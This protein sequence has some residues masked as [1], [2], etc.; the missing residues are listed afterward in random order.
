MLAELNSKA[1]VQVH[2]LHMEW[3]GSKD[4][5][6][7]LVEV[8]DKRHLALV[9]RAQL[10]TSS[11]IHSCR[12]SSYIGCTDC[13]TEPLMVCSPFCRISFSSRTRIF[14]G[15]SLFP[16]QIAT[17]LTVKPLIPEN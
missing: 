7:K 6:P 11:C 2:I 3:Q 10:L 12:G 9:D 16:S 1:K 15:L 8:P 14:C 5:V 17:I 4:I 13:R